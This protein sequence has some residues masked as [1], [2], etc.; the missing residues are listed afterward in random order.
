MP[1]GR[2][3]LSLD[4]DV[5]AILNEYGRAEAN[6]RCAVCR[7]SGIVLTSSGD[8]AR[9]IKGV[10]CASCGGSGKGPLDERPTRTGI[11]QTAIREWAARK[12]ET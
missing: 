2:I 11:I 3:G 5:L 8:P 6:P 12:K 7:G 4:E 1:K 10:R 9:P